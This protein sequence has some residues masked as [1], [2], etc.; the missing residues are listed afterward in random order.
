LL[1]SLARLHD[2]LFLA[3][4]EELMTDGLRAGGTGGGIEILLEMVVGGRRS[5][6]PT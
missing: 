1:R 3:M 5:A 6:G 4:T 2:E